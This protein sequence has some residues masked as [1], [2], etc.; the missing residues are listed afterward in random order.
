MFNG[1][2]AELENN[3]RFKANGGAGN[4]PPIRHRLDLGR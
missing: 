2:P 4:L 3:Q 1:I